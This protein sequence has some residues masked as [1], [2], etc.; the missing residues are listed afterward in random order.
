MFFDKGFHFFDLACW[1]GKSIP[2]QMIVISRSISS[3]DFL[4][5]NDFSDA[6]IN[7][8]LKNGVNVEM[9][10]SRKNREGNLENVKVY[11]DKF[12]T[13]LNKYADKKKFI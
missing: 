12:F 11:G 8:K 9:I 7:M 6:I 3:N 1:L 4:K 2:Y 5:K 13:E 10:F